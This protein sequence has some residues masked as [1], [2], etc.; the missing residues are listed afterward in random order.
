LLY[1]VLRYDNPKR[2]KHRQPSG[3]GAWIWKAHQRSVPYR[4]TE[5]LEFP[6]ATVHFT[7]GE[8]DAD[9]LAALDLCA[10][11]IAS[12]KWTQE[13]V[14]ALAGRHVWIFEDKDQAGRK[15]AL[16]AAERLYP[17]TAGV[18]IIRLPGLTGEKNSKDVDLPIEPSPES[19]VT[20]L[21][22]MRSFTVHTRSGTG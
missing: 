18:K 10:T 14:D 3:N 20:L 4:W 2:F 7:E 13:I 12:N 6:D 19:K 9:T 16:E 1:E 11:T 17:V 22:G 21:P 15:R 8:K 5:L